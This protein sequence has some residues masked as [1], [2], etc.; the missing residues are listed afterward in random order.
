MSDIPHIGFIVGAYFVTAAT[1]FVMIGA[2][3]VDYR[4]L[5]RALSR[6]DA[7]RQGDDAQ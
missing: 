6:L 4:R 1:I 7:A 5:G 3:L 2:I